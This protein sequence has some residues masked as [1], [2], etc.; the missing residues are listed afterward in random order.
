MLMR[1]QVALKERIEVE[2]K[3]LYMYAIHSIFNTRYF[4][5][6]VWNWPDANQQGEKSMTST[7]ILLQISLWNAQA[8]YIAS[9]QMIEDH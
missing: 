9:Q 8:F 7:S 5:I 2:K 1:L 4:Q 3:Q 6:K